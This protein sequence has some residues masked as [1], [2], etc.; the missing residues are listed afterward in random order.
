VITVERLVKEFGSIRAVDDV[1]F[2]VGPGEA[3]GLLGP[4]GSGKTTIMRTL[5]GFFPPTSGN[6][7]VAGTDV[8]RETLTARQRIGYLPES[9][10]L[11]PDMR[12]DQFLGF[13]ADVRGLRGPARTARLDEIARACGLSTVRRRLI[14][15]LSKG[16]RQRVGLAQALL[17]EPEVLILDEPTVGLDPEQVIEIRHLIRSLRGRSAVLLSTHILPEVSSVCERVVII[18]R[19]RLVVQ[20][21]SE[22][23]TRALQRDERTLIRSQGPPG[24]IDEALR[25]VPGVEEVER[26][27]GPGAPTFVV[28]THG[29][30]ERVRA[31][32]AR[33][34]VGRGWSLLEMRPIIMTLEEL[35]VRLVRGRR[36]EVRQ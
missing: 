23:L 9:A 8:A 2:D 6:V 16:F 3:L 33:V 27:S 35:F 4:N 22:G 31:A 34:L 14:G 25:A 7:R 15:K 10:V 30:G 32:I 29:D 19:G 13:C 20:D 12:V 11:Y 5:A 36:G 28:H 21:T 26:Q 24:E 18:D 1:S 17:H